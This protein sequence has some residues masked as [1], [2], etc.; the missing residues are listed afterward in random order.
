VAGR[1]V[2]AAARKLRTQLEAHGGSISTIPEADRTAS[3]RHDGDVRSLAF[4]VHAVRVAV[5]P[6]TGEVEILRSVHAADAGRVLNYE[7]CRGQ[8]EGGVAQGIGSALYE[9]V[10]L[11]DGVPTS[12]A[13]RQYR[14]PQMADIPDTE[15]LFADTF[16]VLGPQGAKSMSE[17]PF[18]PV[19]PAIANAIARAVGARP[20]ELPMSRDRVWRLAA[21]R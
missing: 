9:E 7:Q 18:N 2:E 13:F 12:R 1:A 6:E 19:A 10:A 15:V 14:V 8:V 20:Y 4:N 21:A 16:D 17:S 5:S 3:A 11:E